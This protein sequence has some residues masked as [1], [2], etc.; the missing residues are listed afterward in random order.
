MRKPKT[1]HKDKEGNDIQSYPSNGEQPEGNSRYHF[2][3]TRNFQEM[4]CR[5]HLRRVKTSHRMRKTARFRL[6]SE[7]VNNRRKGIQAAS[8]RDQKLLSNDT[9]HVY[10]LETSH[11][12]RETARFQ[13]A[14][15]AKTVNNREYEI[16]RL[17]L[18]RDK[19]NGDTGT[20]LWRI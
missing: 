14:I 11:W 3:E 20:I 10:R 18:R 2:V 4:E 15:Q 1:R 9:E 7:T 16:P 8:R 12:D 17:P 6:S 5:A 13:K 19:R